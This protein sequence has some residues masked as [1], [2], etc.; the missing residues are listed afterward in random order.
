MLNKKFHHC[1][2]WESSKSFFHARII[3][4]NYYC[5]LVKG[6]NFL[7]HM[8]QFLGLWFKIVQWYCMYGNLLITCFFLALSIFFRDWSL[9]F[10][11]Q[12]FIGRCDIL[13]LDG[14]LQSIH[15]SWNNLLYIRQAYFL[16]EY[17]ELQKIRFTR[18]FA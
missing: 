7:E 17:M 18:W 15:F 3:W 9:I 10:Q 6:Y 11:H 2:N 4:Q 14:V 1:T 5:L 12:I 16:N 13:T 8:V